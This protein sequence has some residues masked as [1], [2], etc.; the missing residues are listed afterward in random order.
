MRV[1]SGKASFYRKGQGEIQLELIRPQWESM[2]EDRKLSKE[3]AVLVQ[4]AKA[5][6]DS[7]RSDW[8]NKV[9]FGLGVNDLGLILTGPKAGDR[10]VNLVHQHPLD[11]HT[12]SLRIEPG[13]PGSWKLLLNGRSAGNGENVQV[14]VYLNDSQMAVVMELAKFAIPRILGWDRG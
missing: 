8:Q 4:A 14:C 10:R 6:P 1:F 5:I 7:E 11:G 13:T 2:G 3:G 12:S 9:L